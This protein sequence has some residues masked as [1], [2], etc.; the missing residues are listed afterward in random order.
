MSSRSSLHSLAIE[1]TRSRI[2][3]RG[4][5]Q[6]PYLEFDTPLPT[7]LRP[8]SSHVPSRHPGSND[9][10]PTDVPSA[11]PSSSSNTNKSTSIPSNDLP[12]PPNLKPYSDPQKWSTPQKQSLVWQS[13]IGTLLT[14]YAAGTYAPAAD[15][16][17][18]RFNVSTVAILVGVTL[19]TVGFGIAPMILAPFSELQGR[20]PVFVIAGIIF[21][22]AVMGTAVTQSYAGMM[23]CR[24]LGGLSSSVFSTM[25]GGVVADIYPTKD[26]NTPMSLFAGGVLFGTGLGPMVGGFIAANVS[27]RWVFGVHAIVLGAFMIII[28]FFFRESRGSVLLSR[29]AKVL[30]QWYEACE[31]KGAIGVVFEEGQETTEDDGEKQ[32]GR[33]VRIRW[34]CKADEERA[35]LATMIKISMTRPFVLLFTEPT[36]FFFSLWI[37]FAWAILY[38]QFSVIPYVFE[39]VYRF[40]LDK[41]NAIFASITITSLIMTT[42]SIYQ[43]KLTL[44]Y[45]PEAA[46]SP[47]ARLWFAAIESIFLPIGLFWFGWTSQ[48]SIHWIVP[49]LGLCS[50]TIGIFAIYLATFNYLADS[51]LSFASS[52]IAGQSLCRNLLGGAFPLFAEAFFGNVGIGRAS[53]ILGAI[54]ALLSAVPFVLAW[55]GPRIRAR[56]RFAMKVAG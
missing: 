4:E 37:S 33:P 44:K 48:A 31:E 46:K 41:S 49:T 30:N 52:A 7:P 16:L 19:F 3:A 12:L 29:R 11:L 26:R 50:A 34:R 10:P 14:A 27:W 47:E 28:V 6:E 32:A 5:I 42:L 38:L 1:K 40:P 24:L 23:I 15:Q 51:Y 39:T 35:S 56:S 55:F 2:D 17:S 9:Q 20:R 21:V 25:V 36:V 45:R 8:S 22:L 18:A 53:S 54:G 43:E 13:V